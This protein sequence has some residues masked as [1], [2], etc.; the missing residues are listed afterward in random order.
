MELGSRIQEFLV[1]RRRKLRTELES[2]YGVPPEEM[3]GV[4]DRV[5]DQTY[6]KAIALAE[7]I[8]C[9]KQPVLL[10]IWQRGCPICRDSEPEFA[11]FSES[12]P[13]I[14]PIILDYSKSEGLI[15]HIFNQEEEGMLPL[16]SMISNG[17]LKM[18]S[19]GQRVTLEMYETVYSSLTNSAAI[20]AKPLVTN[21]AEFCDNV[22]CRVYARGDVQ[23]DLSRLETSSPRGKVDNDSDSPQLQNIH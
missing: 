15:Y 1:S 14:L 20:P 21:A 8:C 13:E 7:E 2:R 16:I 6:G 18:M 23:K 11:R 17:E 9:M 3:D 19:T 12:H 10:F 5:I 4:V 22:T